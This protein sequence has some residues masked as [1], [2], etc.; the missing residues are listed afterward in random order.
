[1]ITSGMNDLTSSSVLLSGIVSGV[2]ESTPCEYGIAY[3]ERNSQNW[4]EVAATSRDANGVLLLPLPGWLLIRT[5]ITELIYMWTVKTSGVKSSALERS[6]LIW[7]HR[8]WLFC[9]SSMTARM[10]V[11]GIARGV[12]WKIHTIDGVVWV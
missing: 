6:M 8:F 12:G 2:D 4:T 9:K 11:G 7:T 10:E 3:K 1:M 5:M